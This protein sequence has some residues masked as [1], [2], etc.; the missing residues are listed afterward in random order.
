MSALVGAYGQAHCAETAHPTRAAPA[1]RRCPRPPDNSLNRC[2]I[3]NVARARRRSGARLALCTA[4][5]STVFPAPAADVTK[6]P[7]A[8]ASGLAISGARARVL[9][10]AMAV[11]VAL[12][13]RT[14]GL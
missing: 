10:L 3:A 4:V 12:A 11:I 9:T 14:T 5:E 6:W 13:L 1:H 7:T 2:A 8:K